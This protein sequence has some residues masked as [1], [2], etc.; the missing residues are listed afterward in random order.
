M[1]GESRLL[2]IN[3]YCLVDGLPHEGF[4]V[5]VGGVMVG[6]KGLARLGARGVPQEEPLGGAEQVLCHIVRVV[7]VH[8][9][10]DQGAVVKVRNLRLRESGDME[11]VRELY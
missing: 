4:D 8:H 3:E 2:S 7:R 1:H 6:H 11:R 10:V 5:L 9:A